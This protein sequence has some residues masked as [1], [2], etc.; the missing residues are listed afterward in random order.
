[1]DPQSLAHVVSTAVCQAMLALPGYVL[2]NRGKGAAASAPAGNKGGNGGG[3][4]GPS[5]Q[6]SS[7][8]GG[9]GAGRVGK[10]ALAP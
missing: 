1:M 9:K 10:G 8:S 6:P 5:L 4:F 2:Q 3:G 7:D